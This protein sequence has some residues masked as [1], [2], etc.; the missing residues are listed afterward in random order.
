MLIVWSF[1]TFNTLY[2]TQSHTQ[3]IDGLDSY[4]SKQIETIRQKLLQIPNKSTSLP[5]STLIFF[6][7]AISFLLALV[8]RP[9]YILKNLINLPY[10]CY[11]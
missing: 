8:S 5:I 7:R 9:F 4:V 10:F 6:T 1:Q 3:F 2:N 11:Y